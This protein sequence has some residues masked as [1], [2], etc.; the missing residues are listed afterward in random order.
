MVE[1]QAG[2]AKCLELRADFRRELTANPRQ[3]KKSNAGAAHI[4]IETAVPPHQTGDFGAR[5]R[6]TPIDEHQMQADPQIRQATG[7]RHGVSR[8][9]RADHQA[10][11]RQNAVPVRFFDGFVDGG[12]EPEIVR[13]D[14][15]ASQLAI[16][17][18][19]RNWKN[20]TP[21]RRR[22]RI[23]SGLLIISATREAILPRR[24]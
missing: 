10:R 8:G 18:L 24:K 14:D 19:R 5:E 15:Q 22:R 3:S 16:S 7:A 12:I 17:R 4:R 20:S 9:G 1:M 13:A 21:S 6:R 2:R 11:G 23:I